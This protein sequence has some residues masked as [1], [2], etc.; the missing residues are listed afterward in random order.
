MPLSRLSRLC[1]FL[2]K[3]ENKNAEAQGRKGA[4]NGKLLPFSIF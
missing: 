1:D 3:P 4:K 2:V